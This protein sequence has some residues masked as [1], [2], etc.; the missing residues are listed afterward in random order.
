MGREL[1]E[2]LW[3][4]IVP[5]T[6]GPAPTAVTDEDVEWPVTVLVLTPDTELADNDM[7]VAGADPL[8]PVELIFELETDDVWDKLDE[9]EFDRVFVAAVA[10]VVCEF[11]TVVG[12]IDDDV[13]GAAKRTA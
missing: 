5:P 8:E 2:S 1:V 10:L 13:D 3:M 4:R 9:A 11:V 12:L 6:P 7:D